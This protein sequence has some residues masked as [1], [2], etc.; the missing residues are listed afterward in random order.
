MAEQAEWVVQA[1]LAEVSAL[2][3]EINLRSQQQAILLQVHL[4]LALGIL[5]FAFFQLDQNFK[6]LLTVPFVSY[7]FWGYWRDHS[8]NISLLQYYINHKLKPPM[9]QLIEVNPTV[10][11]IMETYPIFNWSD[12][13]G[14]NSQWYGRFQF[15]AVVLGVFTLPAVVALAASFSKIWPY[16]G[17]KANAALWETLW[18]AGAIV[19]AYY[20]LIHLV[21]L[22]R[23]R[24]TWISWVKSIIGKLGMT[25]EERPS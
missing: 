12:F 4:A 24:D 10:R 5:G 1:W 21:D 19:L 3:N 20:I 14:R 13:A 2:R 6:V 7:L 9:E 8:Y 15:K 17:T 18:V 25:S 11:K 23:T 16:S 22:K